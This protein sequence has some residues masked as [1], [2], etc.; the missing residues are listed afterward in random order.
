MRASLFQ[1]RRN[2]LEAFEEQ[3]VQF[4]Q[5]IYTTIGWPGVVAAMVLESVV[6]FLPSEVI[7][8]LAGWMLVHTAPGILGAGVYGAIG[9][10]I[11]ALAIYGI[12]RAGGRPLLEKYGRYLMISREELET[13]D[14]WFAKYGQ[15]AVL[16]SRCVPIVRTFISV[17]AGVTR[18]SLARFTFYSFLGSFVWCVVLGG[19]G[20]YFGEHWR[21]VRD[22]MRPFDLPILILLVIGIAYYIYRHVQR[23]RAKKAAEKVSH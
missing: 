1:P 7:M 17:P 8:P 22:F 6:F 19:A 15:V 18:M 2:P 5:N 12:S 21:Q 10:T 11:A 14:R 20:F 3:V 16:I 4:I 13:S 23:D 9:C